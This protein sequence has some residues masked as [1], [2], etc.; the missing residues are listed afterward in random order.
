[1]KHLTR[2]LAVLLAVLLLPGCGGEAASATTM[3]LDRTQGSVAVSDQDGAA[4]QLRDRLPLYS[5]YAAETQ[6]ASYAWISLDDVKLVKLDQQSAAVVAQE[7]RAL[8]L[9]AQRG[10]LLFHVTE[11]LETDETLDI[12]AGNLIVGIRGTCG[13]VDAG[14]E[15]VFLLEGSVSCTAGTEAVTISAGEWAAIRGGALETG[16]FYRDEIPAFV[17][18]EVGEGLTAAIPER[19]QDPPEPPAPE[20]PAP[21]PP[22]GAEPD[23]SLPMTMTEFQQLLTE[24]SG[25][26]LTIQPGPD[27]G[28]LVVDTYIWIS[29][30]T[31]VTLEEGAS[32]RVQDG[33]LN[34]EGTLRVRGDL[35]ND[36]SLMIWEGGALE[37]DGLLENSGFLTVGDM[38][39]DTPGGV[40]QDARLTAGQGLENTGI[41]MTAG[42]LDAV[43]TQTGGTLTLSG[44]TV[45]AVRLNGGTLLEDGGTCGSLEQNGGVVQQ[46]PDYGDDALFLG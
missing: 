10:S 29:K 16:V 23:T 9:S 12:Q 42:Q 40:T 38:E 33:T 37:A 30:G 43:V 44:G 19:P 3:R 8:T 32:L 27:G 1:M 22:A 4:V 17:L 31:T 46:A 26:E 39:K 7:G 14:G 18:D 45:T 28:E 13:W 2:C 25:G 5:G 35:I 41:L 6:A 11:P 15:Q 20:P 36:G 34:V 24:H 21:E